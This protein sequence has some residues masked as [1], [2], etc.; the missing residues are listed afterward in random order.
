MH[1][2]DYVGGVLN[3]DRLE[4]RQVMQVSQYNLP[5]EIGFA[6]MKTLAGIRDEDLR[7]EALEKM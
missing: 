4:V 7:K 1:F 5:S 3:L 2:G 6:V